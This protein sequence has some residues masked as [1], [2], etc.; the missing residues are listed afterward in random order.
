MA[1][2]GKC[3]GGPCIGPPLFSL[4]P[5]A[6]KHVG[7]TERPQ[8]CWA[9][10][11]DPNLLPP[12]HPSPFYQA[13]GRCHCKLRTLQQR[14]FLTLPRPLPSVTPVLL[15]EPEE[16]ASAKIAARDSFLQ[17]L[18]C[19]SSCWITC[20]RNCFKLHLGIQ[21]PLPKC[22]WQP[23]SAPPQGTQHPLRVGVLPHTNSSSFASHFLSLKS[24]LST[25]EF[26]C[27]LKERDGKV[28]RGLGVPLSIATPLPQTLPPCLGKVRALCSPSS[29]GF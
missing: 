21:V 29:W 19:F 27:L 20:W 25:L 13:L 14:C 17:G 12:P 26:H 1:K 22:S 7:H 5:L 2:P 8:G 11:P 23:S 15:E 10:S 4:C 6:R 18:K 9:Q 28:S 16:E 3:V 24:Q